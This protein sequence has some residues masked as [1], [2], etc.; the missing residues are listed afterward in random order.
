VTLA[1]K[2]CATCPV[3]RECLDY[4][5]EHHI[6]HGVWGGSSERERARILRLRRTGQPVGVG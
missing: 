1:L 6:D 3:C 2:I 5:L 4:A